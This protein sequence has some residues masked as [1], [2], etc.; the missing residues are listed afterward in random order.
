MACAHV[1]RCQGNRSSQLRTSLRTDLGVFNGPL[2]ASSLQ[3]RHATLWWSKGN[4]DKNATRLQH[5]LRLREVLLDALE[6][7]VG[8]Q[9]RIHQ[10][11]ARTTPGC[12]VRQA[13]TW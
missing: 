5:P 4:D 9:E 10:C 1:R 3:E 12:A 7:V 6:A 8:T 2:Q 11:C 13:V